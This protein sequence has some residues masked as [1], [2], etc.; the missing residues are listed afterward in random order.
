MKSNTR[1]Y[2][3]HRPNEYSTIQEFNPVHFVKATK[4]IPALNCKL[5]ACSK[6]ASYGTLGKGENDSVLSCTH[7]YF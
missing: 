3:Q 7:N 4:N 2:M 5:P 1:K 6:R